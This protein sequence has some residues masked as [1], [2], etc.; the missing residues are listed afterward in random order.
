MKNRN[1]EDTQ[2][3]FDDMAL[4]ISTGFGQ[5]ID[6]HPTLS[7]AAQLLKQAHKKLQLLRRLLWSDQ[8][9]PTRSI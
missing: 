7:V 8:R 4:S 1:A 9:V 5:S 2:H 6:I 3:E